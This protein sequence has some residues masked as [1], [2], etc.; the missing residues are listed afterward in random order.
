MTQEK[1]KRV[2]LETIR[3]ELLKRG[4]SVTS[5][6]RANGFNAGEVIKCLHRY[7]VKPQFPRSP[8]V[9][10]ILAAIYRDSGVNLMKK[11]S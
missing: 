1:I 4:Y 6:S 3:E 11:V 5:W 10:A 7:A 9:Y 2:L 8:E